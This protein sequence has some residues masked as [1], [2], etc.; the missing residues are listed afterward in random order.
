RLRNHYGER[1]A[2]ENR[3]AIAELTAVV[4][5]DRNPR[6]LFD[7]EL[8]SQRRMPAGS[9]CHDF[10]LPEFAKLFGRDVHLVQENAAGF[11]SNTAQS[12]VADGARLLINFFEH[13]MLVAAFFRHDGIPQNVRDLAIHGPPIK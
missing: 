6:Q 9:T 3:I 10:D 7:H 4:D 1:I 5:L 8:S 2:A 12:S 13:E 11:L